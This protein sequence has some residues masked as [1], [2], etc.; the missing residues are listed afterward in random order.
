MFVAA[1]VA[2]TYDSL[3]IRSLYVDPVNSLHGSMGIFNGSD[4]LIAISK[5][6]E[7]EELLRFVSTLKERE[8]HNIV[9]VTANKNSSLSKLSL[10]TILVPIKYEGDHLGLAPISSTM[11]FAAVLDSISVQ[12]SSER[13]YSR[14]DFVF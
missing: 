12:L 14:S 13:G 9:S 6:G 7:T 5:S 8:F 4:L 10:V 3:G 11:A 1:R 2:A